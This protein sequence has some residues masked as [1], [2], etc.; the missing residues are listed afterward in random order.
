MRLKTVTSKGRAPLK[1]QAFT[2]DLG[3]CDPLAGPDGSGK[4]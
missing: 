2:M 3:G 4:T 1:G